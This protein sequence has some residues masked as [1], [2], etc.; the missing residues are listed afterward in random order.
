M[1]QRE[2]LL[3]EHAEARPQA[4]VLEENRKAKN[5]ATAAEGANRRREAQCH[6]HWHWHWQWH[7]QYY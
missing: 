2:S 3:K 1:Q 7:C 6:C 5:E 4:F